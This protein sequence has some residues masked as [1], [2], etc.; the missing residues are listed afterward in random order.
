MI[1]NMKL[2]LSEVKK[3]KKKPYMEAIFLVHY[4]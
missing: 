3:K 2:L 1:S 4:E